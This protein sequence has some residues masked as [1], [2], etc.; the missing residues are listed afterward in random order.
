MS[1]LSVGYLQTIA[2]DFTHNH[3][4]EGYKKFEIVPRDA[5]NKI[6][7]NIWIIAGRYHGH[8]RYGELAFY[9]SEGCF[10][11][12]EQRAAAIEN[13]T[14]T[15]ESVY[16]KVSK[17]EFSCRALP[18]AR[19]LAKELD[20]SIDIQSWYM[21][22]DDDMLACKIRSLSSVTLCYTLT[23]MDETEYKKLRDENNEFFDAPKIDKTG[24]VALLATAGVLAVLTGGIFAAAEAPI[25]LAI[26]SGLGV[27]VVMS[28]TAYA[29]CAKQEREKIAKKLGAERIN[30]L[31]QK[32][33][34]ITEAISAYH[35]GNVQLE[36]AK[37]HFEIIKQRY[38]NRID[39]I[40][41]L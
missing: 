41:K 27:G 16:V 14:K 12:N 37:T 6:F 7:E 34:S 9:G 20:T 32:I 18:E 4:N 36:I 28:G 10:C 17:S 30:R 3:V 11:T 33:K 38:L 31:Q 8:P 23:K 35:S 2:Y 22:D 26:G 24:K 39:V 5:K 15:I 40:I 1:S 13:Y 29:I 25:V 21:P 19:S